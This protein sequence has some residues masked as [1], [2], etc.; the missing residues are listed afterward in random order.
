MSLYDSLILNGVITME[1]VRSERNIADPFT[2]G[3]NRKDILDTSR[4]M[5][6]E[7]NEV[8]WVVAVAT[9]RC[10][11]TVAVAGNEALFGGFT[12][13]SPSTPINILNQ[14]NVRQS[15]F[16]ENNVE[17]GATSLNTITN[18]ASNP[19]LYDLNSTIEPFTPSTVVTNYHYFD[20]GDA[21]HSCNYCGALFWWK[22]CSNQNVSRTLPKYTKC[23]YE[24]KIQ[25]PRMKDPPRVLESLYFDD[26]ERSRHFLDNIRRYN[27]MFCFTSLGGKVDRSLNTGNVPPVFKISGQNYHLIGSLVPTEG[28]IPKFAQLYIYD[29]DN[30]INNRINSVR[31]DS[32]SRDIN[33]EIVVELK[34]M[35][36]QNNVLVNCFRMARTE[37]QSNPVVE[38]KMNLIGKRSKDGR[39]YNLPTAH[40]VAALIVGD[41][42]PLMSDLDI[43]IETRTG[44]LKRINRLNLAYLPLQYP[45]LFPY[46]EDGYR[47]DIIFSDA[48]RE[49]HP[50]GRIRISPKEYFSFYIHEKVNEKHTLLYSRRLFQQFLVD[51]Y[52]MIEYARLVYIRTHQKSLR[53]EAYQGL[54]DALTR[55]ELDPTARGKRIILPSTFTGGARYMIQNYQDAMAICKHIG[56][57]HI[58]ITF[59]SNP[60]WPEIERMFHTVALKQGIDL[61]SF[62]ACLR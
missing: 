43:L 16:K 25:L 1:F 24:G 6:L 21:A 31:E 28:S 56:Y 42:D 5:G 38:V 2:K 29:I 52:T 50:G 18:V 26:T 37:I 7:P 35:L 30:E 40:E 19:S 51:A 23:C 55:G 54:S 10:A 20:L 47:E 22:E 61:T 3:L 8:W 49:H 45:L 39:T 15:P 53:C 59:T 41:L 27:N 14:V 60:K 32:N 13:C 57:P 46:D 48:W 58:F 11:V 12:V 9:G 62:V 44:Q 4:E 17:T 34:N 36:D 33:E